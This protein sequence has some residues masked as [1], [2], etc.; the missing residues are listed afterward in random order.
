MIL[1]EAQLKDVLAGYTVDQ[2][3]EFGITLSDQ[4]AIEQLKRTGQQNDLLR[5][6]KSG[7]TFLVVVTII[8]IAAS[9]LNACGGLIK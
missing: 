6:I 8:G 5:S 2:A 1:N 4:I 3:N 7:V 9:F